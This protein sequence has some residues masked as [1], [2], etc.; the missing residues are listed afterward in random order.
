MYTIIALRHDPCNIGIHTDDENGKRYQNG[1]FLLW[2][3][4]I[5]K[6]HRPVTLFFLSMKYS[7]VFFIH[8]EVFNFAHN[9]C[10]KEKPSFVL[11]FCL[12]SKINFPNYTHRVVWYN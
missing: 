11:L 5:T 9:I 7:E 3:L 8:F 6:T 4:N 10:E 1:L 12:I 2:H